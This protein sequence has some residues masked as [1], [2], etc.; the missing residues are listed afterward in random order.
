[1]LC[2]HGELKILFV[3]SH[4][5]L[6]SPSLLVQNSSQ[7]HQT[8]LISIQMYSLFAQMLFQVNYLALFLT[9]PFFLPR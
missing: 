2:P 6:F 8:Q 5:N 3:V 1:M 9:H 4:Q 7:L